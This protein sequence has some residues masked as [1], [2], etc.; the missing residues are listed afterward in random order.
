MASNAGQGLGLRRSSPSSHAYTKSG[1]IESESGCAACTHKQSVRKG[2]ELTNSADCSWIYVV[3]LDVVALAVR[4]DG[5]LPASSPESRQH[6]S[7]ALVKCPAL[8]LHM[9]GPDGVLLDHLFWAE[10]TVQVLRDA[11]VEVLR[12]AAGALQGQGGQRQRARKVRRARSR[13]RTNGPASKA[14]G[15]AAAG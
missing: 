1:P 10:E 5:D 2:L 3:P 9:S 13:P 11:G 7:H 6:A 15:L 14:R 8:R 12:A 4:D